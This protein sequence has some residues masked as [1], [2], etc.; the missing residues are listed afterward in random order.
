MRRVIGAVVT[1]FVLIVVLVALMDSGGDEAAP[2]P[3]ALGAEPPAAEPSPTEPPDTG[4]MSE[5][6]FATFTRYHEKLIAETLEWSEGAGPCATIGQ[7]GDL[8]GFRDCIEEA[9]SGFEDA[10]LLAHSNAQETL[11]VVAK[12]CRKRLQ[13]Y[14]Q[15]TNKLY[16]ANK[17]AYEVAH[18]LDFDLMI[19]AF[20]A[21]PPAAKQYARVSANTLTQCEPR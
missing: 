21:L 15:V 16:A 4:R 18:A 7:T 3:P 19:V 11:N 14:A 8:A 10:A 1:I 12:T 17:T 5:G 13:K 6:E 2:T 20:R 9:W